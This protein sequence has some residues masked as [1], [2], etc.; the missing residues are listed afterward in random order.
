MNTSIRLALSRFS[1]SNVFVTWSSFRRS[2]Q[3][4]FSE[5][6]CAQKRK[7]H[8]PSTI[9]PIQLVS[10]SPCHVASSASAREMMYGS[11]SLVHSEPTILKRAFWS[12]SE[13]IP[14]LHY[15]LGPCRVICIG[16]LLVLHEK[17]IRICSVCCLSHCL[18]SLFQQSRNCWE[19]FTF[20]A[21]S[22]CA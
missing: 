10:S 9:L 22:H 1:C 20:C 4:S 16:R 19:N 7:V 18:W 11:A 6:Y 14:A 21:P 17:R 5:L 2:F 12:A 15:E 13:I 8:V 3:G